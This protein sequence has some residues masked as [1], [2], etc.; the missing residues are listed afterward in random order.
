L[1]SVQGPDP[2]QAKK[3]S[4]F[5]ITL[6]GDYANPKPPALKIKIG[7]HYIDEFGI[8]YNLAGEVTNMGTDPSSFTEVYAVFYDKKGR[9]IE[10][11]EIFPPQT[12]LNPSQS[13]PFEVS[14]TNQV[15]R[16]TTFKVYAD[17]SEYSSTTQ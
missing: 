8:S 9:V 7:N 1:Y 3:I 15:D 4:S 13:T 6:D 5:K 16:I 10:T 17:S 14:A 2:T 12:S 11:S